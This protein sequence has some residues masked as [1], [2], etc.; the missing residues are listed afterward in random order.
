MSVGSITAL[1]RAV[2]TALATP[3]AEAQKYVQRQPMRNVDETR[4]REKTKRL[5]VWIS[6]TPL[7]TIFRLLKTRGTKGAKELVGAE[8]WGT[9]GTDHYAGYH[10]YE[11][12]FL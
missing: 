12:R 9:I 11:V 2:S 5:W 6:V 8:V 1:E 3:V 7:V 4:W 10:V